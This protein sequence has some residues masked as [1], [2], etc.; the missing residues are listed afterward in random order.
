MGLIL[1]TIKE[2]YGVDE[3]FT[4]WDLHLKTKINE[5]VIQM[6]LKK[7]HNREVLHHYNGSYY[8]KSDE[9]I[10]ISRKKANDLIDKYDLKQ[11]KYKL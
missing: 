9:E 1:D 10:L 7:M 6:A 3:D 5:K 11:K 8:L 2:N 4:P